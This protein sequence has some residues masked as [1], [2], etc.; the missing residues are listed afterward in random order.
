V[1]LRPRESRIPR[2]GSL[3]K[4]PFERLLFDAFLEERT[5]ALV[6][7][8]RQIQ[9]TL[10]IDGGAPVECGSNLRHETLGQFLVS[11]E[12][13]TNAEFKDCLAEA[14]ARER[15]IGDVLLERGLLTPGEL[16]EALRQNLAY[17]VLECFTWS[18]GEFRVEPWLP[19]AEDAPAIQTPRVVFTGVTKFVPQERVA[20]ALGALLE[21]PLVLAPQTR[22]S[23]RD[24][25]TTP[26][27]EALIRTLRRP[28]DAHALFQRE[29]DE[30]DE[31]ARTLYACSVIE[32][33]TAAES[34]VFQASGARGAAASAVEL[35]VGLEVDVEVEDE[36][37]WALRD[38]I[39]EEYR[40]L[41]DGS[42]AASFGVEPGTEPAVVRARYV[43]L[44]RRYA[45][46]RFEVPELAPVAEMA[47]ELL[48]AA[49]TAYE[50]HRRRRPQPEARV[51]SAP[52]VAPSPAPEPAPDACGLAE[53]HVRQAR[54]RM[55]G[56]NFGAAAGLLT[57]ALR[58]DPGNPSVRAELAYARFRESPENAAESLEALE[59]ILTRTPDDAQAHLFAAEI[60]HGLD[61][62]ERAVKHFEHGLAAWER[63]GFVRGD[64]A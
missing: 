35:A 33:V 42:A 34:P 25:R 30:R 11:R 15:R 19:E 12:R 3:R 16:G 49:T 64:P 38:E 62:H 41:C 53:A 10:W 61:A 50:Q 32:L 56:G 46:E 9:K 21:R 45:P 51:S 47:A 36:T 8:K 6:L 14:A 60:A 57:L 31:L 20:A 52:S 37:P 2:S 54:E 23:L 59:E 4:H 24:L 18:E 5:L 63:G 58:S 55:A 29:G 48:H 28:T 13:I 26:M 7:R 1:S 17:K 22:V 39:A 40:A 44:C 43:D 27:Q